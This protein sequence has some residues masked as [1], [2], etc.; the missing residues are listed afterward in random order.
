MDRPYPAT[1][2]RRY[3]ITGLIIGLAITASAFS[4]APALQPLRG[5]PLV[6]VA[7]LIVPALAAVATAYHLPLI[8]AG[9]DWRGLALTTLISLANAVLLTLPFK[10]HAIF[11]GNTGDR[12][13]LQTAL[14]LGLANGILTGLIALPLPDHKHHPTPTARSNGRLIAWG[15]ALGAL[16][17]FVPVATLP[18][19]H[20]IADVSP[21]GLLLF[22]LTIPFFCA[23]SN[24]ILNEKLQCRKNAAGLLPQ[25]LQPGGGGALRPARRQ[26]RPGA[27]EPRR[28]ADPARTRHHLRPE[29][30]PAHRMAGTARAGEKINPRLAQHYPVCKLP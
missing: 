14:A 20:A 15:T 28:N 4:T 21:Y 30:R 6:A 23:S 16:A 19:L 26:T 3:T 1:A 5:D 18:R 12:I 24:A 22:L 13:L 11:H 29:L 2:A 9:K 25:Q 7:F 27:D 10:A 8:Q 17:A